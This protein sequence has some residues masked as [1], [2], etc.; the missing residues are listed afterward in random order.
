MLHASNKAASAAAES[1]CYRKDLKAEHDKV[2]ALEQ[3]QQVAEVRS[4]ELERE[5]DEAAGNAKI[6]EHELG[7]M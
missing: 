5:R 7:R 1:S 2:E 6:A 4:R 3:Q